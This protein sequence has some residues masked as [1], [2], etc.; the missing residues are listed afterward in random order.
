[1]I[2]LNYIKQC[3][4]DVGFDLVG[5]IPQ[6][7]YHEDELRFKKWLCEGNNAQM[8]Y[9]ERNIDKRFN[10]SL[11][12]P[13][14]RSIIVCGVAYKN[15]FSDG[16]GHSKECKIAS[17]ALNCDYHTTI[18]GM[19]LRVA[20]LLKESVPELK[21]RA[22]TD[23]AP[24][25]EKRLAVDAGIGWIGRQSLLVTPSHGTFIHLGELLISEE[26]TDYDKPYEGVGCGSCR[27]C[28]EACPAQAILNNRTIDARRCISAR[29]IEPGESSDSNRGLNGWIFGCD[30]CQSCC[31][32]NRRVATTQNPN[33]QPIF[34]PTEYTS[35]RWLEIQDEEFI[36]RFSST[37]L[38]R[39]GLERIKTSVRLGLKDK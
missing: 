38:S 19:L 33:F 31:P 12:M 11:L 14:V 21:F 8:G 3:G 35:E 10:S 24:L 15:K 1:M 36:S 17:Y 23:S 34:N 32:H 18:K 2:E 30:E 27:A 7:Y 20:E 13:E 5:V 6:R 4:R 22:F 9:L 28:I 26:A 39:A 29:T 25:A 37:P 16:Y